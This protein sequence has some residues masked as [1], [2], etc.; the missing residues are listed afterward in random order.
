[1]YNLALVGQVTVNAADRVPATRLI[2]MLR[3]GDEVPLTIAPNGAGSVLTGPSGGG[4]LILNTGNNQGIAVS[5]VIADN[6]GATKLVITGPNTG[7]KTVALKTAGLLCLMAMAGL[8]IPARA[9]SQMPIY[10]NIF[11]DIGDDVFAGLLG[12]CYASS[13]GSSVSRSG[14]H[15]TCSLCGVTGIVHQPLRFAECRFHR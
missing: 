13:P 3:A 10:A 15:R 2:T 1:M 12:H 11:A 14:I 8:P 5:G 7:G 6:G 4:N 9:G